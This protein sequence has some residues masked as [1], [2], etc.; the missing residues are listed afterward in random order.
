[1]KTSINTF[2]KET[3]Q[4]VKD[5]LLNAQSSGQRVRIWYGDPITGR[6]WLEEHDVEGYIGNS[7][8]PSKIPIL[9]NNTRSLG[10][11]SILDNCIV[12]IRCT[13]GGTLYKHPNFSFPRL[14]VQPS[15]LPEYAEVVTV[16][17]SI[18][19]RFKKQGQA[20]RWVKRMSGN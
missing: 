16:D 6:S 1:M 19:A 18:H 9:V 5:A 2:H 15:D 7:T 8:G 10:G 13:T 12:R 17:G 4:A 14:E 11:P 20:Q 3:S